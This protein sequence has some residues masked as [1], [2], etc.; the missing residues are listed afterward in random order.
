MS[1]SK[2]N[3]GI[4]TIVYILKRVV[5]L[6]QFKKDLSLRDIWWSK[7]QSIFNWFIWG[8]S[9]TRMKVSQYRLY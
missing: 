5:P 6:L 2:S 8:G 3:V 1:P 9:T 7:I 4:Q